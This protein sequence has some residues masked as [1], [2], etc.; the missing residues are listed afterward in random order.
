MRALPSSLSSTEHLTPTLSLVLL[1]AHT[2]L[3]LRFQLR[4]IESARAGTFSF[5][6][7]S[8]SSKVRPH[9]S[10]PA[11]AHTQCTLHAYMLILIYSLTVEVDGVQDAPGRHAFRSL[12]IG[13]PGPYV[14]FPSHSFLSRL[15]PQVYILML[16]CRCVVFFAYSA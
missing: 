6:S 16:D 4:V 2:A 7:S 15:G 14:R 10:Q 1:C 11:P 9:P 3:C 5:C 8:A 12:V 13:E